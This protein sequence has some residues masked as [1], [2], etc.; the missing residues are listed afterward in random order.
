MIEILEKQLDERQKLL[1]E[2]EKGLADAN[3][4]LGDTS[5]AMDES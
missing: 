2:L 4:L 1:A 5:Q 3:A